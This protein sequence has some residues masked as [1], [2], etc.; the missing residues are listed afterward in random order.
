MIEQKHRRLRL[1]SDDEHEALY[2]SMRPD[3]TIWHDPT[4]GEHCITIGVSPAIGHTQRYITMS[5][6]EARLLIEHL[7][8]VI[9]NSLAPVAEDA[10]A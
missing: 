7:R 2:N 8:A 6:A 3:L 1:M 10:E 9:E 4:E 5:P